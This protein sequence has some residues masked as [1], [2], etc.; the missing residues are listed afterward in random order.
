MSV[1]TPAISLEQFTTFGDL[2]KYLRRREGMTQLELSFA[3]G[4]SDAMICRLEQNQRL[5]D[6]ATL[7]ARFVPALGV[8]DEPDAV[9]RLLDLAATMRREDAPA[10]GLP[11]Y[12]GLLHFEETDAELFFGRETLTAKLMD[13][14]Q[15]SLATPD[16]ARFLAIVG[17]SGS[18]KSSLVRAGLVP[19]LR[20]QAKTA[21]W[22]VHVLTPTAHPLEALAA[23]LI[24]DVKFTT[25]KAALSD[26]LARDPLALHRAV[27]RETERAG[28]AH[29][30]VAVDQFEELFTLCR[31]ETERQAFVDNLMLA[32]GFHPPDGEHQAEQGAPS[33]ERIR[34]QGKPTIGVIALRADFYAH[35][36]DYPE[37]RQALSQHQEYIGAMKIEQLRQAIE[38]PAKHGS[39]ELEPGLVDILLQ[40]LQGEPGALPLLSHALL[41]T[42][43]RR[44]GRALTLSGYAATGG[45]RGAIAETAEAVFQDQLN[46]VQREIARRIFLRLTELGEDETMPD[47]RRRVALSELISNPEDAAA[48]R[49]VL[50]QLADAR[51]ITTELETVEVAHEALIREWPTLREWLAE[52]REGLRLHRRLTE[53]ALEWERSGRNESEMYRGARL[54]QALEWTEANAGTLN[55][56]EHE[57]LEV[58]KASAEREAAER[59]AQRQRELDAARKLAETEKA[60][61]E[62]QMQ[63]ANRLRSRNRLIAGAGAVVLLLAILAALFGLQSNQNSTRAESNFGIAQANA[64]T[65][66]A[67]S[68][69]AESEKQL[70]ISRELAIAA[71]S[72]LEID[73]E[74]SILLALHALSVAH[75]SEAESALHGAVQASRVQFAFPG[76]FYSVYYSPDGSRLAMGSLDGTVT[77]VDTANGQE[78]LSFAAHA[79][80]VADVAF[81]PDGKRLA[82]SSDDKTVKVWD[83]ATGQELLTLSGQSDR[84]SA[85]VFS[86][87][88]KRLATASQDRTVKVWDALTG[89]EL[90][91]LPDQIDPATNVSFSPDG[92]RLITGMGDS[93]VKVW[94]AETGQVLFTP[95]GDAA[96]DALYS[97]D[98]TRF[99]TRSANGFLVRMW[100]A[101]TG[102]ELFTLSMD[103]VSDFAFSGDGKRLVTGSQ[104][105]IIKVWD[106][107]TG[108]ELLTTYDPS[109]IVNVEFSPDGEHVAATSLDGAVRVWDVS[110]E[111]SREWLTLA[112]HGGWVRRVV[113]SPDGRQLA[114]A[115]IDGTAKVFDADTGQELFT[116]SGHSDFVFGLAYSPDGK[117]LATA[118]HD[119]TVK[120]WDAETGEELLTLSKAGHGDGIVGGLFTG[121]LDVAFGPDGTRLASAGADGTAIVWDAA[122]GHEL[123]TL[124]NHGV[125]LTTLAFS[126]DGT[127]LVTASD[128]GAADLP[129]TAEPDATATIWD[130]ATSQEIFTL[131]QPIRIWG[132]AFDRDGTRLATGAFG[133]VLRVWNAATG[134]ELLELPGH[135]A[136][137][138]DVR[139]SPDGQYIAS[140]S[141]DGTTKVWDAETGKELVT[142][143]G[144]TGIVS[145]VAF[146]P[147][148]TRLATASRDG[149][150]RVYALRLEDL[151]ALARARVTRLLTIEEC[152]QY[153][154]VETCP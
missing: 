131:I 39:W 62:E 117:R 111:G 70:A 96:H 140:G 49:E 43:Q 30:L 145:G 95:Q 51:L 113:Y 37:L 98:G 33:G 71:V 76:Q 2:L 100:N 48:V 41:E 10:A 11:P 20:W 152:Q 16:A 81:S 24:G 73:P 83:A 127:R 77:V 60:R 114:T 44:R 85:I 90:L 28:V 120:V 74:R 58:S 101:A 110:S 88:G 121:I 26:E 109:G 65:A 7:K 12:R 115:G 103:T 46:P 53:A 54:A 119:K 135:T 89:Q 108:A 23:S 102:Q 124:S 134:Q 104:S 38:A 142:L 55:R 151:I 40:D 136:S 122:N 144:H 75:T 18:G 126:P 15:A 139:F 146:S 8:E 3:V 128:Q 107:G 129:E 29:A 59:E 153:L 149:T 97:P 99:A 92:K 56:L 50:T 112:P 141:A 66:E 137:I 125:G 143:T 25:A 150:M 45:V 21:A 93:T 57:F 87:D 84:V 42:W 80:V 138:I 82:T 17:A 32:V 63:S 94:D 4:Y 19:A 72:N 9:R 116:L 123:F 69:R 47:T 78:L 36:A 61:A 68:Q 118:S 5:P 34:D 67:E 91:S 1:R 22:P 133:G 31:R 132:L 147:D 148:G 86:P 64:A 27:Q 79:A 13:R 6:L 52:D 154:H 35:C 105:G 106:A 14:L 130:L